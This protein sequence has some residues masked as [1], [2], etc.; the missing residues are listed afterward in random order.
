MIST[1][2]QDRDPD[3]TAAQVILCAEANQLRQAI[4]THLLHRS[5]EDGSLDDQCESRIFESVL[6]SLLLDRT[7]HTQFRLAN[8]KI[9]RFL[10]AEHS[11][12][13]R[14]HKNL[15]DFLISPKSASANGAFTHFPRGL[16]FTQSRKEI[17]F[18]SIL[19]ELGAQELNFSASEALMVGYGNQANWVNIVSCAVR[20]LAHAQS[21][22][23]VGKRDTDYLRAAVSTP[24]PTGVYEGHVF[25][26]I[27]ALLALQ[28]VGTAE[29][30][31]V[32]GIHAL[33]RHQREDGGFPFV[34][35]MKTFCTVTAA[36][37]MLQCPGKEDAALR[38]AS[39]LVSVQQPDGGWG[40]GFGVAQTDADD[41]AYCLELIRSCNQRHFQGP[42]RRA[43]AY[44]VSI[45]AHGAGVP[46][47]KADHT[48]EVAMTAGAV[49]AFDLNDVKYHRVTTSWLQSLL[50][51]QKDDGTFERS[52]SLSEANAIFRSLKAFRGA[53][54]S[55]LFQP[56]YDR[57]RMA[58]SASVQYL[59]AAQ[60]SDGGWGQLAGSASDAI[61]T[62]YSILA[63]PPENA[64]QIWQGISF[65]VQSSDS[66]RVY[67]IPDQAG[68]RPIPWNVPVLAD[69]TALWALNHALALDS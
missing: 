48:P 25:A 57:I 41:T 56:M 35:T 59:L 42:I 67:S 46:T 1:T 55:R 69:V 54:S 9:T 65:I 43:E 39:Y 50:E 30:F 33:L 5:N 66:G 15:I 31:V 11:G 18:R 64:A 20:V 60:N 37:G 13:D 10:I 29:Q 2:S 34:T 4:S 27:M 23:V 14:F 21:G 26:H 52:W 40:Y 8:N 62:A 51:R 3:R 6:M 63:L 32:D 47:F 45:S 58:H 44:L 49:N 16:Q 19:A 38:A 36:L 68:P 17:V 28:R 53:L 22:I 24:G 12:A 61:S 7:K